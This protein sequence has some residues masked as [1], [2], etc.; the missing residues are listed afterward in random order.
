MIDK[1]TDID[2]VRLRIPGEPVAKGRPRISKW[3][4]YTPIKTVNY[5]TLIKELFI[6]ENKNYKPT[7]GTVEMQITAA[8]TIPKSASKKKTAEMLAG[9]IKP[10]KK[11]D[12]DNILK[13][14]ADA[15]NGLAYK[16]DRQITKC[17]ITKVYSDN[18]YVEIE[19]IKEEENGNK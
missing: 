3:G 6:V 10:T 17:V 2:M 11:P 12:L 4:T 7:E 16:D 5:E 14:V 1:I 9:K 8:F 18:P 13:I 19:I 15:L